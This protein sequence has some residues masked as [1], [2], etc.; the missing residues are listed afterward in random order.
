M[1]IRI[2]AVLLSLGLL[3]A[4]C[5]N[6]QSSES[7]ELNNMFDT[8]SWAYGQSIAGSLGQGVL[9]SLDKD[10][11]VKAIRH[12]LEGKK[13]PLNAVES[14]D[15]LEYLMFLHNADQM[16]QAEQMSKDVNARQSEYLNNL[17]QTNPN[18]KE[19]PMGFLYEVVREGKGPKVKLAQRI[20]FDYRSKQMLTGED[21]DQT[22][23]K[24]PPIIHVVGNPMFPGLIEAFQLM[25]AGSLYRFYFPYQ[26]AFGEQGS[27]EI[28]GYT[29]FIYEVELHE[30]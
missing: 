2:F 1:K 22:Y 7:V 19:H 21:Y 12:S 11:V 15:A 28:P 29:P 24:R 5:G 23:G 26:L 6:K 10:I 27:G 25:N 30:I 18:V 8:L 4:A 17:K 16:R 20:R 13:Q 14:K 9:D 3:F